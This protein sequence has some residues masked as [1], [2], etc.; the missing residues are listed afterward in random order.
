MQILSF[1]RDISPVAAPHVAV[2][3][4]GGV[5]SLCVRA[6]APYEGNQIGWYQGVARRGGVDISGPLNELRRS[7]ST[8]P[9]PCRVCHS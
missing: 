3:W 9:A 4:F 1:H 8:S 7:S 2:S 5:H 6:I